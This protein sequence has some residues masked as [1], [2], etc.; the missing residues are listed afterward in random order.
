[1]ESQEQH[2]NRERRRA[3]FSAKLGQPYL[4]Q[5]YDPLMCVHCP[6]PHWQHVWQYV[7]APDG[8]VLQLRCPMC[9]EG[10]ETEQVVC[11]EMEIETT[12][13]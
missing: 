7:E 1:M 4:L 3:A 9:A 6:H 11:V 5:P 12:E 13:G 2:E 10:L 8:E